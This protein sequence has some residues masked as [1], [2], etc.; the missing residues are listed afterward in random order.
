MFI[1]SKNIKTHMEIIKKQFQVVITGKE[2]F[3]G[4]RDSILYAMFFIALKFSVT[5]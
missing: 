2:K 4:I 3:K 1:F 5:I